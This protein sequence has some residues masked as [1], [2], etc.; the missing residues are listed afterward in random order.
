M[1]DATLLDNVSGLSARFAEDRLERQRRRHLDPADFEALR[2]AGVALLALPADEGGL[3]RG[4]ADSVRPICETLRVLARGDASVALVCAM[5]PAVLSYW[6]TAPPEADGEPWRSQRHDVFESV[7]R[8]EWWGTIT[9][10]PGS[11][12]DVH[13]TRATAG[14][15]SAPLDYRLSGRKHFGSGSGV[16]SFMVTTAVPEGESEPDW[17]FVDLRGAPWDGSRG[18]RL[19]AEWDGHGMTA[20]QSHAM[21]FERFPATRIAWTGHLDDISARTGGFIACLFTSVIVGIVDAALEAARSKIS[22]ENLPPFEQVE[23][24]R[25]RL[26][27]WLLHQA[28]EGMLRA[29][30]RR[31][32]SRREALL[33]KVAGAELAESVLTRISK[34][35]G[36]GTFS[37]HSPFGFWFEDVRALGFLRPPWGLAFASLAGLFEDDE[38]TDG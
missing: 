15:G 22:P 34:V 38:P 35:I 13:R 10:E 31:I 18:V 29:A 12:G 4:V 24:T 21:E 30:E 19:L 26:D 32:D 3:W 8:G 17:F 2:D 27:G 11:G 6:L 20:T 16:T 7:R 14:R 25:A 28:Y 36:G 37:R 33:G 9:S 5:H 23:W 1:D